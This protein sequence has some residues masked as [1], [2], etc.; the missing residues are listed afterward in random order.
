LVKV[1]K[2]FLH[3]I[4]DVLGVSKDSS[5]NASNGDVIAIEEMRH[6][7]ASSGP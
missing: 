3:D 5:G 7:L 4:R 1:K 2:G 6:R